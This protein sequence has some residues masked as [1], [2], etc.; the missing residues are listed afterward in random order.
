MEKV[1][2]KGCSLTNLSPC[3]SVFAFILNNATSGIREILLDS[4][5]EYVIKYQF[6]AQI[7][8]SDKYSDPCKLW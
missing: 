1:N 6:L 3:L 8:R 4:H 7:S 5:W 2:S